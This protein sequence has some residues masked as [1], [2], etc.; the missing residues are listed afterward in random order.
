M[1]EATSLDS[2]ELYGAQVLSECWLM[3]QS[4]F[5]FVFSASH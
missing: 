2:T 4:A 3:G 1:L 5:G